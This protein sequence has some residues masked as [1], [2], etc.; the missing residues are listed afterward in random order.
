MPGLLLFYLTNIIIKS[1][2]FGTVSCHSLTIVGSR[3]CV[4]AFF[5]FICV[6]PDYKPPQDGEPTRKWTS[7]TG[8]ATKRWIPDARV[9]QLNLNRSY[10][11]VPCANTF[12]HVYII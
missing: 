2:Y 8:H 4:F 3:V 9:S 1:I 11:V 7:Y 6:S 5:S 10:S 12:G